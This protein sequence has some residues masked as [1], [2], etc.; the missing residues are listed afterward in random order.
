[1][2]RYI[3]WA[4]ILVMLLGIT[5]CKQ[6]KDEKATIGEYVE[7]DK[8]QMS[9]DVPEKVTDWYTEGSST[10]GNGDSSQKPSDDKNVEKPG[11]SPKDET[12]QPPAEQPE[13]EKPSTE[14]KPQEQ[15]EEDEEDKTPVTPSKPVEPEQKPEE[16]P[17]EKLPEEEP[18]EEEQPEEEEETPTEDD[19]EIPPSENKDPVTKP[20]IAEN[21]ANELKIVSYNVRCKDDG[22]GKKISDRAPRFK[23]LMDKYDPDIMGLQEVVPNWMTYLKENFSDEYEYINKWRASNSKEGT[24]IFWKKD[25]FTCLESGYFWLSDTPEKESIAYSWGATKYYRIC[26]WVKLKIKATGKIVLFY[27]T[28]FDTTEGPKVPSAELVMQRALGKGGF[29]QYPVF[30]TG[31]YNMEPGAP[32]YNKMYERF[33]DIN[34]DLGNDQTPT[35]T[36]YG[37]LAGKIIDFCF[38]S[39]GLIQP[40]EYKVITELVNGG[41]ISDHYGLYIEAKIL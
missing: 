13:E 2:K 17:E 5:G 34:C 7:G 10:L 21:K 33:R 22:S 41:H 31:D 18:E 16:T 27:N 24:P 19:E 32:A 4:L 15:P 26:M 20:T 39:P 30:C 14:Q 25:K 8:H 12:E 29:N 9:G 38:Y 35:Y 6:I 40:M 1:M 28:H 11:E 3:A 23:T 36:K 37:T